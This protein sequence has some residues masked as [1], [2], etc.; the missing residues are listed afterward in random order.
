MKTP[1]QLAQ[2]KEKAA[3]IEMNNN[4]SDKT[5]QQKYQ[6]SVQAA[7]Q[8]KQYQKTSILGALKTAGKAFAKGSAGSVVGQAT[9]PGAI[10]SKE[11][12][13]AGTIGAGAAQGE[14]GLSGVKDTVKNVTDSG[15]TQADVDNAMPEA[16]PKEQKQEGGN[17]EKAPV[18]TNGGRRSLSATFYRDLSAGFRG[19]PTGNTLDSAA[20]TAKEQTQNLKNNSANRQMEAQASQQIAN[21]NEFAEAGKIA[22]MQNNAENKQNIN[23][24]SAAAGSSAALMRKTNT[25]DVQSQQ[26]RQDQQR[27][28]ANEQREKADAS[29]ENATEMAGNARNFEIKSRDNDQDLDTEDRLSK[30]ETVGEEQVEAGEEEQPATE[31]PVK[32]EPKPAEEP[33]KEEEPQMPQGNAQHVINGLL[34]SSKGADLRSGQQ[35]AKDSELYQWALSQGVTPL[36][37]GQHANEDDVNSW[38]A[39]FISKNGEKGKQLM[40]QLRQGRVGEG[41]DASRNFSQNEMGEMADTMQV[42]QN[43]PKSDARIKDIHSCMSDLRMKFIKE[44]WDRDGIPSEEDFMWLLKRAGKFK[45]GDNEYDALEEGSDIT[46]QEVLSGY[47]DFIKNYVYNYKPESGEDPDTTH[48]GPMAQD[49]EQVNP[50]CIKEDENGI[51]HVDTQRLSMMNA[52]AIGELARMLNDISDRLTKAGI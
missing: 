40:Q 34:G 6:E 24:L 49:I 51:K 21:R 12:Q 3:K 13:D 27:S 33:V 16:K 46:D 41:K 50:A 38:E 8:A 2:D 5:L 52:G 31:E 39:E 17:M 18:G 11:N 32:E 35:G 48:I 10:G 29:Q 44:D 15:H 36:Q 37:A 1:L 47:A 19:K 14:D 30:G 4:P 22:S 23:N 7:D 25:P 9:G 20:T 42:P 45:Q 28:V 26:A 43:P